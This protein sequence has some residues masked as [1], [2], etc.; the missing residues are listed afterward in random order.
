MQ[1][2]RRDLRARNL[3]RKTIKTYCESAD[4]LVAHLAAAGVTTLE[5]VTREQVWRATHGRSAADRIAC[6]SPRAP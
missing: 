5:A 3:A 4:Q 2:W 6:L 1:S